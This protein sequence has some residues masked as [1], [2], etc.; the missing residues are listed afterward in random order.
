MIPLIGFFHPITGYSKM[1]EMQGHFRP[2]GRPMQELINGPRRTKLTF[3]ARQEG[4][5]TVQI[6][7]LRRVREAVSR[8]KSTVQAKV[9]DVFAGRSR[10]AESEE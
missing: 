5:A 7:S 8:S 9:A 4:S 6:D 3:A 2:P 1:A 10:H